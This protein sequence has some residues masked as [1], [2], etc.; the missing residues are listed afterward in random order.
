MVGMVVQRLAQPDAA[1]RGWLLD[2]FP[3]TSA[4]AEALAAAGVVPDL[5]LLVAV[6]DEVLVDGVA[7]RRLDPATGAIYHLSFNPPPADVPLDRLVRAACWPLGRHRM[8]PAQLASGRRADVCQPDFSSAAGCCPSPTG[9]QVQRSDD[10]EDKVKTRLAAFHTHT[11]AVLDHYK[12]QLVEVRGWR[13]VTWRG[14][15]W[16][17]G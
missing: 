14:V 6:P 2:G 9:L 3:R 5:V 1:Q 7:G 17:A 15:V 4:Q 12:E 16:H 8:S 13:G 10:T 11:Q